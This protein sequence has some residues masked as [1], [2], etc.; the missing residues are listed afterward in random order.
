MNTIIITGANRGLGLEF[1]RQYSEDGWD[2]IA[3]CRNLDRADGLRALKVKVMQLDV[4]DPAS[5]EALAGQLQGQKIDLLIN[6]AGIMGDNTKTALDAELSEWTDAFN[7][8]VLAPALLTR[9]LVP[10]L[11]LSDNPVGATLGSQAGTFS[12]MIAAPNCV[13]ASTKAAAHSV[14]ISLGLALKKE[15]IIYVSL[16][17]GPTKTDMLPVGAM[18]EVDDS[19]RK[20]RKVLAAVT[21]ENAGKFMD[22]TG[23]EFPLS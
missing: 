3:T 11:K 5:C 20:M 6:N 15:G 19:V 9:L 4:A 16:R 14:T 12:N 21:P 8:N 1:A 23:E 22:R 2:V 7:I 10:N 17:P 18:Y 13:Y